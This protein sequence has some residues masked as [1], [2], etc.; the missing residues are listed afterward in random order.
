[1][2]IPEH[3]QRTIERIIDKYIDLKKKK[4]INDDYFFTKSMKVL[5]YAFKRKYIENIVVAF[6]I[7]KDKI[8]PNLHKIME[9]CPEQLVKPF[10]DYRVFLDDKENSNNF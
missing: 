5:R 9:R 7:F 4:K 2:E 8:F 10:L 6:D 3:N 1:M